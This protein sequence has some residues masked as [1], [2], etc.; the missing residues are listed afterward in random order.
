MVSKNRIG[1]HAMN[2]LT[3]LATYREDDDSVQFQQQCILGKGK[4][5]DCRMN[6]P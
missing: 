5:N 1:N 2:L 6:D 4:T 3:T